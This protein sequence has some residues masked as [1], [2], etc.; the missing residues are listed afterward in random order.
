MRR[1]GIPLPTLAAPVL[2]D[3]GNMTRKSGGGLLK[4]DTFS[5]NLGIGFREDVERN[6]TFGSARQI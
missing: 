6:L 4:F 5:S 2:K 3:S 1:S